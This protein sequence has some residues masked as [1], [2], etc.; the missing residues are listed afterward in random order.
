MTV[1]LAAASPSIADLEGAFSDV[2]PAAL[3]VTGVEVVARGSAAPPT[4]QGAYLGLVG[5]AGGFQIGLASDE[6][7][8]QLL[9]RALLG[10]EPGGEALSIGEMADAVCEIVNI[11]AGAFKA[12]VR[13]R[14]SPLQM[15]LPLFF[16]GA[17][18]ETEHTALAVAQIRVGAA[19]AAL[20][21]VFPRGARRA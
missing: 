16:H 1:T 7:G 14:V 17:V 19:S 21:L 13:E 5:P 18:Q 15:G 12:R 9:A 3:G 4:W 8:C 6:A 2:A 10:M 11:V 20:V